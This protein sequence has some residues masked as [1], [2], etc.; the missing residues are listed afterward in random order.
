MQDTAGRV[1]GQFG[2]WGSA[3]LSKDVVNLGASPGRPRERRHANTPLPGGTACLLG[4][5]Q[6]LKMLLEQGGRA[7]VIADVVPRS[8]VQRPGSRGLCGRPRWMFLAHAP[9]AQMWSLPDTSPRLLFILHSQLIRQ[10]HGLVLGGH[11]RQMG[12]A[13]S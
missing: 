7:C 11:R 2:L 10:R 12:S 9:Q 6:S 5:S 3:D 1:S 8:S 13:D 4:W